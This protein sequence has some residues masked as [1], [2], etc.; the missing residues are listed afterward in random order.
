[1]PRTYCDQV[2]ASLRWMSVSRLRVSMAPAA[3]T[4]S[5]RSTAS[6][7]GAQATTVARSMASRSTKPSL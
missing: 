3:L 2:N 6:S 5:T 1:M 7:R 4:A